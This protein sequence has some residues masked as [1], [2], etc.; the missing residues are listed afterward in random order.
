[1][2][3]FRRYACLT[4]ASAWF[5]P[6]LALAVEGAKTTDEK[7]RGR[8]LAG[9]NVAAPGLGRVLLTFL[10]VAALAWGASWLLRR[11]GARF[12]PGVIGG[13]V[14]IRQLA[15]NTLPGGVACHLIEAQG[16]EVLITVSRHGV[17]SLLLGDTPARVATQ[18]AAMPETPTVPPP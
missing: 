12:R 16:R 14:P 7:L 11:Y 9:S 3:M 8:G 6:G 13:T 4:F 5:S 18:P 15:R 2:R 1:M 17:S 10:L